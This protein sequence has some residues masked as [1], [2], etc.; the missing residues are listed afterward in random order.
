MNYDLNLIQGHY[1]GEDIKSDKSS[2]Q[3]IEVN[4]EVTE[5]FDLLNVVPDSNPLRLILF[6]PSTSTSF[7]CECN[8]IKQMQH[9]K[10]LNPG[11]FE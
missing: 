1:P 2:L 5:R 3:L 9:T 8:I 10:N 4:N 7:K 11:R 6:V